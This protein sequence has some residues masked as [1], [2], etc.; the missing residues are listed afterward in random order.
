M[1]VR[2]LSPTLVRPWIF[3][4]FTDILHPAKA[5]ICY[6]IVGV[7]PPQTL[8]PVFGLLSF[9]HFARDIGLCASFCLHALLG[10]YARFISAEV[11]FFLMS[12]YICVG[13]YPAHV[14]RELSRNGP[15]SFLVAPLLLVATLAGFANWPSRFV[16]TRRAGVSYLSLSHTTLRVVCAH[17]LVHL[18]I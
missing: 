8:P 1:Q 15:C 2:L 9:L 14:A 6:A 13:H 5:S 16:L 18:A 10:G 7:V 12:L 11:A 3:H 17:I 4:G